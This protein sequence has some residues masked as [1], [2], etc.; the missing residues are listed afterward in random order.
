VPVL[1]LPLSD[2]D[3]AEVGL[4]EN[5]QRD[6]LT[7]IEEAQAYTTLM[8]EFART[9]EMVA[10][11]VG[12][13]RSHVANTLRLL[14]TTPKVQKLLA[15]GAISAGHARALIGVPEGDRMLDQ[16]VSKGLSVR[17]V[18]TLVNGKRKPA[19][20][21]RPAVDTQ[22]A[23]EDLSA[24]W[25]LQV[26]IREGLGGMGVMLLRYKNLEQLEAFIRRVR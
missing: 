25:G 23:A 10:Q 16:I 19:K 26:E 4:I 9:Q 11:T 7:P 21:P 20:P 1:V 24:R 12:K 6:D 14:E 5:L 8:T 18:E 17:Q 22:H 13:S 15:T 3:A 2:R